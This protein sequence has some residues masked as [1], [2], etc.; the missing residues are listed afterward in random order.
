M[1]GARLFAGGAEL[2]AMRFGDRLELRL[3]IVGQ[4]E[5][6]E[7]RSETHRPAP[8]ARHA[9][10]RRAAKARPLPALRLILPGLRS[11]G[12]G[13]SDQ[14]RRRRRDR[15][16]RKRGGEGSLESC[17]HEVIPPGPPFRALREIRGPCFMR[18]DYRGSA[19]A[20]V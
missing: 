18:R 20:A 8:H 7:F 9:R 19:V 17:R 6:A 2:V 16:H 10:R 15:H 5:L 4:I 13:G 11:L 12:G 14:H 3:L 1:R